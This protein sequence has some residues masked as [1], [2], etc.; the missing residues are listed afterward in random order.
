MSSRAALAADSRRAW[1]LGLGALALIVV[2]PL[3]LLPTPLA[4]VAEAWATVLFLA[5]WALMVALVIARL[6]WSTTAVFTWLERRLR[7]WVACFAA[8]SAGLWLHWTRRA[9]RT[10]MAHWCLQQAVA[11][12]GSEAQFQYGLIFLEGGFGPGGQAAAA[13]WF[14]RAADQGH[15]EA[16]FR[17]AEVLRTGAGQIVPDRAEAESWYLRSAGLGY[18]PAA[19]WLAHAYGLGDGVPPDDAR[20]KHW[21]EQ[22]E[23][24]R[25]HPELSRSVLRHDAAPEDPLARLAVRTVH[26]LESL[27]ARGMDYRAGRWGLLLGA[28][29]LGVVLLGTFGWLFWAG[30]SSLVHMP[31][32]MTVALLLLLGWQTRPLWADRPR[33]GRDRLLEA[34]E[35]GDP[36]ACHRLGLAYRQGSSA[37]PRDDFSAALWFRKAAEQGHREAMLALSD[38]YLGGHGVLRDRR[39]A[40]RWAEAAGRESTS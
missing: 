3:L 31:L 23:R 25:P 33:S 22:A 7:R 13:G 2:G 19:V 12:G 15:P 18:G 11:V 40:A 34:A 17:L 28:L 1:A 30:S 36:E 9:H 27:A 14:R 38:A 37:R 21:S 20:A 24:L 6:L 35:A 32:L 5:L 16:A 4:R 8:D 10:E 26:G 29:I 39:E